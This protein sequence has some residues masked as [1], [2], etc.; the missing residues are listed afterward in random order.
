MPGTELA[1][2]GEVACLPTGLLG[3][4]TQT[5]NHHGGK[6]VRSQNCFLLEKGATVRVDLAQKLL[7]TEAHHGVIQWTASEVWVS[8]FDHLCSVL[9]KSF[10][11]ILAGRGYARR[12]ARC[13]S[14]ASFG[15][16]LREKLI[17]VSRSLSKSAL[18]L[19]VRVGRGNSITL[20]IENRDLITVIA[21]VV[22]HKFVSVIAMC[23]GCHLDLGDALLFVE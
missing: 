10:S 12:C 17:D 8:I 22:K 19:Q 13:G 14:H 1:F 9:P 16:S 18:S 4:R 11:V 23:A 3:W 21:L 6:V 2:A 20:G 5:I 15:L 7:L